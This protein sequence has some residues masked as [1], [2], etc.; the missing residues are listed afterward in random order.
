MLRMSIFTRGTIE[1]VTLN[2]DTPSP[3]NSGTAARSPAISPQ[4][5]VQMPCAW[6]ASTVALIRRR[7]P[8]CVGS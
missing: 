3:S 5:P 6:P 8:G 7:M 2:S 4:M 1:G